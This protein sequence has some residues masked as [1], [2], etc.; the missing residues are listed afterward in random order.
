MNLSRLGRDGHGPRRFI[1]QFLLTFLLA[2]LFIGPASA[3]ERT[4]VVVVETMALP[5]VQ[6]TTSWLLKGLGD[7]GHKTGDSLDV[8]VINADGDS[9]RAET[10]TREA[11][12]GKPVD[13]VVTIATLATRAA[14]KVLEDKSIPQIFVLVADPVGEGIVPE[15]G[16][17]S[18]GNITGST[19]VVPPIAKLQ[20]VARS[21]PKKPTG[22]P[23]RLGFLYS[24][25][26]SAMSDKND[27]FEALKTQ[28]DIELLAMG[29]PFIPGE[30]GK[31]DMLKAA[32]SLLRENAE[33]IDGLWLA[34]GPNGANQNY[35]TEI[36][37]SGKPIVYAGNMQSVKQGA[38]LTVVSTPE[39]SGLAGAAVVDA[40]LKG[41]KAGEIPVTRSPRFAVGVNLGTAKRIGAVI[42]SAVL[43]LAGEN[44]F[45]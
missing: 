9:E 22:E 37:K 39:I 10:L 21:L 29:F 17:R 28:S 5:I 8:V 7:F 38:M 32:Q 40:V 13:V 15:I 44:V 42:P 1:V 11:I 27:L 20:V 34:T 30:A 2:A 4:R 43:S 25:Y 31:D 19:H 14:R 16:A 35:V 45:N 6:N 24:S 36:Q 41:A 12:D 18:G 23:F 3:S 33:S 26:P